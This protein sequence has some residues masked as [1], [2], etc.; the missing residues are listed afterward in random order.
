MD[1]RLNILRCASFN[2][3][4]SGIEDVLEVYGDLLPSDKNAAILIKPNLNSNMN[5][6]TGN[7]TDLRI[8]S[9]LI[10][11][12]K[13][14]GYARITIGEG[15]NSGFYRNNISVISRLGVDRLAEYHGAKIKDLNRSGGCEIPFDGGKNAYVAQEVFEADM[16]INLPKMKTH[17]EAGMTGCLKNLIG[18]LVGQENKKKAHDNLAEN[19]LKLNEAVH[20]HLHIVDA[21][22]AMEGLGP[23]KGVPIRMDR[24]IVGTDP[25]LIDLLCAYLAGFNF[26]L[27]P[28][29]ALA[30]EKGRLTRA[31]FEFLD[32][33]DLSDSRKKFAP[34]RA[35]GLARFIHNPRRQKFFLKIRNTP[36]FSCLAGTGWFGKL[37]YL[38]DLRQDVFCFEEMR[39]K[40]LS[41]N[42]D[43]CD[44]CG[45]CRDICPLGMYLPEKLDDPDSPCFHCLYC[46][47]ICPKQAVELEGE[48]GF[49]REQVKQ[50][51]KKIRKVYE[52]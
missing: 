19:I 33:L 5:A 26:L 17:F 52:K 36:F 13:K 38:A 7:T 49:F 32:T 37:L 42:R 20:P 30:R 3:I 4:V 1:F 51:E 25:Y 50:Y 34:P 43:L 10:L 22:I 18:C 14:R 27:I 48:M 23:T 40:G 16:L 47:S 9:A 45:L 12:L 46:Y 31:H 15:T 41:V 6:L 2:D 28:A 11:G 29:L 8:L 24:L 21:L 44:E 39:L 35:G